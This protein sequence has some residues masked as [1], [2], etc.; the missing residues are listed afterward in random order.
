[1][2]NVPGWMQVVLAM[3][4][5]TTA[6]G[7]LWAKV[8]RPL[9][10]TAATGEVMLPL[11]QDLTIKFRDVPQVFDILREIV[12]QV[13]T[14]AGSS[15]KDTVNSLQSM[16]ASAVTTL[17]EIQR[18]TAE[19]ADV[20]RIELAADRQ[21]DERDREQMSRLLREQDRLMDRMG[22]FERNAALIANNLAKAQAAVEG[23]ATDLVTSQAAVDG[24]ASDLAAAHDRADAV[25]GNNPGAA[26]D[27]A[28]QRGQEG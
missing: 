8:L 19:A 7:V 26:A 3:A 23:V 28:S 10:R 6:L 13:R 1:M 15:L 4:A 14:D 21:L 24:V 12:A 5:L 18:A 9:I 20:L 22:N 17:A 16:I 11:L 2:D 27:A 25:I